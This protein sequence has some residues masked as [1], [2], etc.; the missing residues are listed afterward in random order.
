M[1]LWLV[2]SLVG[3]SWL[4]EDPE[5]L[6]AKKV[7]VRKASVSKANQAQ[8][9]RGVDPTTGSREGVDLIRKGS[10]AAASERKGYQTVVTPIVA[11]T[12]PVELRTATGVKI[13]A[14]SSIQKGKGKKVLEGLSPAE[15][16]ALRG[17]LNPRSN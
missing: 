16:A 14:R 2:S 15:R 1:F 11:N 8:T 6:P 12:P 3:C 13:K 4:M 5:A 17:E 10:A 7:H 9:E